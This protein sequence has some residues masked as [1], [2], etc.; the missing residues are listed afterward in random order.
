MKF[1]RKR[2][3]RR[4]ENIDGVRTFERGEWRGETYVWHVRVQRARKVHECNA[5]NEKIEK[6]E[7]Y[8]AFT[9]R[10]LNAPGWETWKVHGE[11]YLDNVA[12][13]HGKRPSW[14]WGLDQEKDHGY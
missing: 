2:A 10:N 14:R 11:C 6:G 7:R 3:R 5:C 13:F 9:T 8:V 12:M 1:R 4:P